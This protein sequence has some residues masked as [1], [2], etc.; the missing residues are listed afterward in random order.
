[1]GTK[2]PRAERAILGVLAQF[3]T[4]R[5]KRQVAIMAGYAV[6]GGGFN[7]AL[8]SLRSAGLI[9]RGEPIVPS[10]QGLAVVAGQVEKVPT[11]ADL[12]A[13]WAKSLPKAE[14]LIL[15]ALVG[16]FPASMTKEELGEATGYASGGGGFN[17]ALS[18]LRT[19]ELVHGSGALRADEALA[20]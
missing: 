9:E 13:Y 6:K 17:N 19:L 2:L 18:K 12:V 3:P 16:A 4:G 11:G 10:A 20:C 14:R 1:L 5:T 8:S 7:N 15:E